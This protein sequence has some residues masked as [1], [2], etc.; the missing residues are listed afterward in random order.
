MLG[1]NR[2]G[3]Y[4]EALEDLKIFLASNLEDMGLGTDAE[5]VALA[6]TELIRAYWG[7]QQIYIPRGRY[8]EITVR[9][10]KVEA[11]FNGNKTETRKICKR[12]NLTARHV[13]R[14]VQHVREARRKQQT[15]NIE[16][17]DSK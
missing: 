11:S 13:Y 8:V 9:D 16:T 14:I 15:T 10:I 3:Q 4:P 12:Y 2:A 17:G 5:R 7:G 6:A 1:Q